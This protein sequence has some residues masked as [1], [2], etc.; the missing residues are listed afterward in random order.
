MKEVRIVENENAKLL[1]SEGYNYNFL[2]SDGFFERWGIKLEDDPCYSP[3]GPEIADIEIST[4]CNNGCDYCYKSNTCKGDNMSLDI[5]KKVIKKINQ[6]NQL[7]QVAFGLGATAEENPELWDMCKI[8]RNEGIIPNGTVANISDITAE[9]IASLFG[10]CAVSFH[11]DKDTCYNSVKRLVDKGLKQVNI[12]QVIHENNLE[13]TKEILKDIKNDPRL[14]DLRAI[15]LLALKPKGRGDKFVP[16]TSHWKYKEIIN[17]A[18]DNNINV[19]FDSCGCINFLNTTK[20]HKDFKYFETLAEGCESTAFS[21]YVDVFG[22]TYPCSFSPNM[23]E[24]GDG[25]D[26]I[27]KEDFLTDVWFSEKFNVFRKKLLETQSNNCFSCRECPL[28]NL[29]I[30]T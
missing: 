7:T 18:F 5:F 28:F 15:V 14:K 9:K 13:E 4:I 21:I 24:W 16:I 8:L 30:N 6:N 11:G 29:K 17:Y 23:E 10:A 20:E 27:N 2:K 1:R 22:K 26:I 3:V 25:M 19:G 12:H